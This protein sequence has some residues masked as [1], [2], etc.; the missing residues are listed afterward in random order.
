MRRKDIGFLV[1]VAITLLLGLNTSNAVEQ[2]VGPTGVLRYSSEKAF[3]GYTLVSPGFSNTSYLL[4]MEG[5][6]VHKWV[7]PYTPGLY[8]ELLPNGNLLRGGRL[9]DAPVRF[10][11]TSG[12]RSG[13][14]LERKGRLGMEGDV[15]HVCTAPHLCPDAKREYAHPGV[16]K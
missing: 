15:S 9:D 8:A 7:T 13:D 1:V 5:N 4:D 11:G 6:V 2:L 16:G 3:D 14:R 10:G 12:H